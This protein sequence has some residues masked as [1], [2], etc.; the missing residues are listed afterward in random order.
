MSLFSNLVQSGLPRS[1]LDHSAVTLGECEV[2]WGPGPFKIHNKW[3]EDKHQM[4]EVKRGW[5][6]SNLEGPSSH[7]LQCKL[8]AAKVFIKRWAMEKGHGISNTKNLEIHLGRIDA[9]AASNGWS[10]SQRQERTK[11]LAEFWKA[12]RAE[13]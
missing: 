4:L 6:M 9:F 7:I 10:D 8:K 2:G 1:V 3:L 11:V 13:E 12:L 5:A